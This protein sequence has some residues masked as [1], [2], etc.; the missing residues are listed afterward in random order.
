MANA[1]PPVH[2]GTLQAEGGGMRQYS[3]LGRCRDHEMIPACLW[4]H[5]KTLDQSLFL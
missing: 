2:S 5:E 4:I 1:E 3:D